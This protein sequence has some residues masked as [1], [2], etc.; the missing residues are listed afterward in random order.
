M[1]GIDTEIILK[2]TLVVCV[3]IAAIHFESVNILWW[4]LLTPFINT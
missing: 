2:A 3:T 4:Y 1:K